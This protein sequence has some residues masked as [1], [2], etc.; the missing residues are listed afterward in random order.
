MFEFTRSIT[1]VNTFGTRLRYARTLRQLTQK[2]L[3]RL[4]GLS[5]GAIGN[6]E[7]DSRRSPKDVFRIAEALN[8]EAA[9]LAMGTGSM[10]PATL[11]RI[12]DTPSSGA[13]WPFPG[14]DPERI[15]ALSAQQRE[16]LESTLAGMLSVLEKR[17]PDERS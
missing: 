17:S 8:V 4:C 1:I 11:R 6:Y 7:T 14:I 9:W 12:A 16:I 3:A 2:E 5:Q 10:E 15:W 13:S